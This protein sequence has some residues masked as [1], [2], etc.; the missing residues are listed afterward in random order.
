MLLLFVIGVVILVGG[1]M[2]YSKYISKMLNINNDAR[3]PAYECED[4]VDYVPLSK[5]KNELIQL[6]NI[7]GT[8]PIYGPI[9]AAVFGPI[10]LLIIPIG[11]IFFG[12]V[13]DYV[14]GV[15][16][17]RNKGYNLPEIA[18]KYI[19][20]WTNVIFTIFSVVLLI[21][22][23]TVFVTSPAELIS[24]NFGVP[25]KLILLIIFI[26]YI[27]STITPIDKIIGKIYPYIA[28]LLLV[29]TLL[30]FISVVM[31][32]FSGSITPEPFELDMLLSWEDQTGSLIIPGFFVMVSCGL[33]SGFHATQTPIVAKTLKSESQSREVFYGMMVVE[34]IIAMIWALV[35]MMIFSPSQIAVATAPELIPQIA[36][37]ALG[38][39]FSWLVIVAVVILPITSGDTAFRSLRTIISEFIDLNQVK[40][41]NRLILAIPIFLSSILLLT[42][43]DFSTLWQYFTWS[44]HML[45]VLTLFTSTAYLR[46]YHKNYLVTLIPAIILF[47]INMIYLFSDPDI[48][49][50]ID[51]RFISI[52]LSIVVSLV[53]TGLIIRFTK[54]FNDQEIS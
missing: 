41:K 20:S 26:Y 30:T 18:T 4:G 50:G 51:S 39:Y 10:A 40:I 11:N 53:I 35:T 44:N 5:R 33:I 16:S 22:V 54:T 3:M 15:I 23:A 28:V 47:I 8:G 46:Y 25:Y 49:F 14:F 34:G 19:G 27:I 32:A 21:L 1:Y 17:I 12:A 7:A 42:I 31:Q 13:N 24:V 29:G 6:L 37:V 36:T 2:T 52:I 38:S 9:A 48:G 45:A 43:I